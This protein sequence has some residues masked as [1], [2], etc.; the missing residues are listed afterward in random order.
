MM[1]IFPRSAIA[2]EGVAMEMLEKINDFYQSVM[3]QPIGQ[4]KF[5]Q[6]HYPNCPQLKFAPLQFRISWPES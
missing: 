1:R 3:N 2:F 5:S 6:Q 4:Y